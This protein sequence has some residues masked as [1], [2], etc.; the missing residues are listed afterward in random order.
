MTLQ[1]AS[2]ERCQDSWDLFPLV[3]WVPGTLAGLS[4]EAESA[5]LQLSLPKGRIS[6]VKHTIAK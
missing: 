4:K 5:L 1:M 6:I 3:M 2:I